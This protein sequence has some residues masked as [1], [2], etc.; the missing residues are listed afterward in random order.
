MQTTTYSRKIIYILGSVIVLLLLLIAAGVIFL[1]TR[2]AAP[3][4]PNAD[5]ANTAAETDTES[6]VETTP[7]AT[8]PNLTKLPLGDQKYSTS[9][10][11][12]YIYLCNTTLNGGGASAAG[13]WIDQTNSTWNLLTKLSVDGV[14]DWAHASV[15]F[16]IQGENRVVSGNGLPDHT[17]GVYP[18]SS[19]DDAYAYD[20]NPNSI[21]AQ[22][23][24]LTFP[25]NPTVAA[26][27]ECMGGEVGIMLSGVPLFN[28]FDAG[29][30]DAA[31]W[32]VQDDCQGHP[33]ASGQYHYHSASDC[34]DDNEGETEHSD[35]MG[36]AL[37]GFGIYGQ[38]GEN[39][40]ILS[41]DDLDECHGHTHEV[42]WD[43]DLTD[44]YH[45]HLTADFPYSVSCFKGKPVAKQ[46]ISGGTQQGGTP[47]P[48]PRQ[49]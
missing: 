12:G 42:M 28:G 10:K 9:P 18:I 47:P 32:E 3:S 17:T 20:R 21:K 37:D 22:T 4:N 33:Q 1:A 11:V 46:I 36:Y 35:L 26:A 13:P 31:A 30:R 6:E 16:T 38:K 15:A 43:G 14:I 2:S 19:S 27:P 40:V 44:I 29:G 7:T 41:T 5:M 25:A 45:Y 24:L 8:P 48:P 34:I 49:R 23:V 39:G